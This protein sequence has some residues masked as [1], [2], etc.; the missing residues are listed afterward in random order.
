MK[1]NSQL[2]HRHIFGS[3]II[4]ATITVNIDLYS[5]KLYHIG[6]CRLTYFIVIFD[7]IQVHERM[8]F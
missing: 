8:K 2:P 5:W 3:L 1:E 7:L 4:G 6:N